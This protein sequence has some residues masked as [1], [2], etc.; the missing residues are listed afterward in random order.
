MPHIDWSIDL[1]GLIMVLIA[2]VFIPITRMLVLALWDMR[3]TVRDI[4]HIVIGTRDDDSTALVTRVKSTE[5][6][7]RKHRDRLINL[8]ADA[9]MKIQDRS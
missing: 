9:G 7:I 6:E 2:A 5:H 8:E 1:G 3:D 4:S